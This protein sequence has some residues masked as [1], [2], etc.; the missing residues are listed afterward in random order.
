MLVDIIP[1]FSKRVKVYY[2]R[3]Q[4]H[5]VTKAI[6]VNAKILKSHYNF[7]NTFLKYFKLL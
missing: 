5:S 4:I 7:K 2:Y 6:L 3:D 1:A